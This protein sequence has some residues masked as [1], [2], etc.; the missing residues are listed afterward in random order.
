[1][2]FIRYIPL[3]DTLEYNKP[4]KTKAAVNKSAAVAGNVLPVVFFLVLCVLRAT[5]ICGGCGGVGG[6]AG[7]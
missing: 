4:G 1:M 5:C 2:L 6:F 7:S 3:F